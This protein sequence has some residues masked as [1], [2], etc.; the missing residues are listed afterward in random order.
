MNFAAH[1]T[2][3]ETNNHLHLKQH[4]ITEMYKSEGT[5]LHMVCVSS[6]STKPDT[7]GTIGTGAPAKTSYPQIEVSSFRVKSC[8]CGR[9]VYVEASKPES[10]FYGTIIRLEVH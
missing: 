1:F 7:T 8:K 3:C 6:I 2:V 4:L 5:G 9:A 10:L